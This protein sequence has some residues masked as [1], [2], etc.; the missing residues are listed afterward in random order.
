MNTRNWTFN[1]ASYCLISVVGTL[2][3]LLLADVWPTGHVR[4]GIYSILL[5]S[6]KYFMM[7]F[8]VIVS[9][10][11]PLYLIKQV[12]EVVMWPQFYV[13]QK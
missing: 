1:L 7:M 4:G 3:N 2:I 5:V 6:L 12:R 11:M 8:I 9:S 10:M 13:K